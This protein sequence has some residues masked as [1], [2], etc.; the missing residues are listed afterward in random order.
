M[1]RVAR[2]VI[3]GCPHHV[4]QRGNQKQTVFFTDADRYTYLKLL[5][6]H[7]SQYGIQMVGYDLMHNHIHNIAIPE[8]AISLAKGFGRVHNDYARLQNIRR[9]STGH[10]WQNRFY[11]CPLDEHHLWNALRYA[12]LNP[13]RAGLVAHAWDWPWSSARAHVSGIDK[14]GLLNMQ[15][16]RKRFDGRRWREFLE[17]ELDVDGEEDK[18][19]YATRTG[20]PLGG[21]EFIQYLESLTGRVLAP[22]KRGRKPHISSKKPS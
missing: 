17:E 12:E 4:T 11:S 1:A 20:R 18:I 22:L 9:Q 21:E 2:I 5:Q 6:K 13:V 15:I 10:F 14:T 7:F 3:P 16:W 8:K 19:R